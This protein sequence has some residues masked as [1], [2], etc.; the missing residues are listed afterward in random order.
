MYVLIIE[1]VTNDKA[2]TNKYVIKMT[3]HQLYTQ[4]YMRV[5]SIIKVTYW[6]VSDQSDASL[7]FY[8]TAYKNNQLQWRRATYMQ[9]NTRQIIHN[10]SDWCVEHSLYTE[11]YSSQNV[12]Q[13]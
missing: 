5:L 4:V 8:R 11:L 2:R 7:T 3:C 13:I 10:Y 12:T 6:R 1:K 9:T